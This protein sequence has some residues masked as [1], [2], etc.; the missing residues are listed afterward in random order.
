VPLAL[1]F[2]LFS[3]SF[4]LSLASPGAASG[5]AGGAA[6]KQDVGIFDD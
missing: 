3:L 2:S 6:E 4:S 5:R 1:R